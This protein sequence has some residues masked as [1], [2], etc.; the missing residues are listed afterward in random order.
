MPS[1]ASRACSDRRSRSTGKAA[2]ARL[3]TIGAGS[4]LSRKPNRS[5]AQPAKLRIRTPSHTANAT[6]IGDSK[7]RKP[8][9]DS[10]LYRYGKPIPKTTKP[11]YGKPVLHGQSGNPY[12]YL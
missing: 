9:R 8:V 6:G 5:L 4:R 10:L 3:Q 1:T 7:N 2:A 12:H 11:R